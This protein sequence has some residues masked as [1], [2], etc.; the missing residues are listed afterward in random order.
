MNKTCMFVG[1]AFGRRI[2]NR[3]MTSPSR[4]CHFIVQFY[5]MAKVIFDNVVKKCD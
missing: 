5:T 4:Q 2:E 3:L 1:E